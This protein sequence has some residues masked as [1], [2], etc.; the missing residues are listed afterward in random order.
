MFNKGDIV[1]VNDEGRLGEYEWTV[2]DVEE[3][4]LGCMSFRGHSG[5]GDPF[6]GTVWEEHCYYIPVRCWEHSS[7]LIQENE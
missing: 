2:L 4:L 7:T 3:S 6:K 5:A 1:K